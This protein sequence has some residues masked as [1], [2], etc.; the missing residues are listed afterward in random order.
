MTSCKY[1]GPNKHEPQPCT[2][3]HTHAKTERKETQYNANEE[4]DLNQRNL[5]VPVLHLDC[6]S[7]LYKSS[8]TYT[9]VN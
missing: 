8:K 7:V 2:R 9:I 4:P 6:L 1:M 3:K 5:I